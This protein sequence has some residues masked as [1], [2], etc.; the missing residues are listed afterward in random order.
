MNIRKEFLYRCTAIYT[1]TCKV[2]GGIYIGLTYTP[3]NRWKQ[4]YRET[5]AGKRTPFYNALRKYG[6]LN[7]D[8]KIEFW[9]KNRFLANDAEIDKIKELRN[10]GYVVYNISDGGG[11]LDFSPETRLKMSLAQKGKKQSAATIEKRAVALRGVPQSEE[12]IA[13]RSAAVRASFKR[14]YPNKEHKSRRI[15]GPK[16]KRTISPETRRKLNLGRLGKQLT[17]EQSSKRKKTLGTVEHRQIL[18]AA[19]TKES[20]NRIGQKVTDTTNMKTAQRER[21]E[22]SRVSLWFCSLL[23][24]EEI[25]I[26][27]NRDRKFSKEDEIILFPLPDKRIHYHYTGFSGLC[28]RVSASGSKTWYLIKKRNHKNQTKTLGHYPEV[29]LQQAIEIATKA[30]AELLTK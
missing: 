29:G 14:R 22:R 4:H 10:Q 9:C 24:G 7:F 11:Q 25:I 26:L 6:V 13:K 19:H 17:A 16:K 27:R 5:K 20:R 2:T 28:L 30:V 3:P 1:V 18:S 15:Y 23:C 21:Q 8:W 12:A